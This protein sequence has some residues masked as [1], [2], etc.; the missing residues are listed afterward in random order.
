MQHSGAI[1]FSTVVSTS[2][3]LS[4]FVRFIATRGFPV[5]EVA[6]DPT[7]RHLPG[8]Q[9]QD[10]RQQLSPAQ[11]PVKLGVLRQF[12]RLHQIHTDELPDQPG[13]EV[14]RSIADVRWT[15]VDN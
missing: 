10:F 13:H 14:R 8:G 4:S 2:E 1:C 3:L 7:H 12:H 9:L 15:D 5:L 11:Q 6:V